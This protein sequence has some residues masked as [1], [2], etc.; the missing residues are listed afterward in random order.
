MASSP[1]TLRNTRDTR[2]LGRESGS[3]YK[4]KWKKHKGKGGKV[5]GK[6]LKTLGMGAE[7]FQVR[8]QHVK[9]GR[10]RT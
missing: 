6:L 2:R 4:G 8:T 5:V 10:I 9:G 1:S 7:P 3:K